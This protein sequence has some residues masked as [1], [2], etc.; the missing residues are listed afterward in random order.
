MKLEKL[1]YETPEMSEERL[2]EI[3]SDNLDFFRKRFPY[4]VTRIQEIHKYSDDINKLILKEYDVIQ[5]KKSYLT[6]GQR[7]IVTGF[8]GTCMIKMTKGIKSNG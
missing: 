7:D 8:V 2:L 1:L 3:I 4:L 5:D 6:R